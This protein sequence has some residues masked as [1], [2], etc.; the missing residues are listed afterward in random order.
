MIKT[1]DIKG[2]TLLALCD[3]VWVG[4]ERSA[5][6]RAE[7]HRRA[8]RRSRWEFTT[9]R[10]RS[11]LQP[12]LRGFVQAV[13]GRG[14]SSVDGAKPSVNPRESGFGPILRI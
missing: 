9:I 2:F 8:G 6:L 10:K 11:L 5:A 4:E 13:S 3:F 12:V 7:A 14:H 1:L